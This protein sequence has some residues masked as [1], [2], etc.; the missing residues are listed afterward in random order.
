MNKHEQALLDLKRDYEP[1]DAHSYEVLR[2]FSYDEIYAMLQIDRYKAAIAIGAEEFI[3]E[4]YCQ[5]GPGV[6]WVV[7]KWLKQADES[8]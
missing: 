5:G 7:E 4:A 2:D 3:E 6:D 1:D 8:R